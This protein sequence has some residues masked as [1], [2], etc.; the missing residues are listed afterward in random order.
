MTKTIPLD[1]GPQNVDWWI[2]MVYIALWQQITWQIGFRIL[3]KKHG[4]LVTP[5]AQASLSFILQQMYGQHVPHIKMANSCLGD[6]VASA[7]LVNRYLR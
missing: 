6:F 2:C 1:E 5:E 7:D 3:L 4:I